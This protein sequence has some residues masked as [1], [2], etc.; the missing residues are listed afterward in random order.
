MPPIFYH[1]KSFP[2]YLY[3]NPYDS[4]KSVCFYNTQKDKVDL[5]D[6]LTHSYLKKE[7]SEEGCFEIAPKS[8][9]LLV[10]LPSGSK[11]LHENG[12]DKVQSA[13]VAFNQ[14]ENP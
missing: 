10:I 1:E 12:A 11:M 8:S 13:V 7:I 4:I 6:A 3:Y 14:N 2:T 9:R 5:Y